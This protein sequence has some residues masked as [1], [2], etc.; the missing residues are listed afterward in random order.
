MLRH[1]LLE[2]SLQ[3]PFRELAQQPVRAHQID[4]LGTG[5]RDQL[6]G[7]ALLIEYRL[8]RLM[9]LCCCHVVD[10]VSHGLAPLGSDQPSSTV[11]LTVP[12]V[13]LWLVMIVV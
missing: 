12:N 1:L 6:L 8:D 5:L 11:F 3:N 13:G 7:Q 2:R 10:R 4:A 9:L